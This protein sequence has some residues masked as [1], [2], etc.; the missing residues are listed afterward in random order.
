MNLA[1]RSGLDL[2]D[3]PGSILVGELDCGRELDLENPLFGGEEALPLLVD[4]QHLADPVFLHQQVDE[5]S[6]RLVGAG[7]RRIEDV[8]LCPAVDLRVA[9]ER[10][11]LVRLPKRCRELSELVT[12]DREAV[13][14]VRR[15]E[16]RLGVDPVDDGHRA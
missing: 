10:R 3:D 11:E 6:D 2:L 15:V 4:L 14:L 5:V 8:S 16:K 13:L 7:Q 9:K 1:V 12:D